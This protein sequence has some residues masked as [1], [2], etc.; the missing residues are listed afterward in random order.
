MF[1]EQVFRCTLYGE[2][3]SGQWS[4]HRVQSIF[5]LKKIVCRAKIDGEQR[6][7]YS[8]SFV[9]FCQQYFIRRKNNFV[10]YSSCLQIVYSGLNI[11]TNNSEPKNKNRISYAKNTLLWPIFLFTANEVPIFGYIGC[12]ISPDSTF[13][14]FV[15]KLAY[16][17]WK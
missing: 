2:F 10:P 3:V 11:R 14:R 13:F 16:G 6:T 12:V 1:C 9:S 7:V 8:N 15:L 17:T 4:R 5:S